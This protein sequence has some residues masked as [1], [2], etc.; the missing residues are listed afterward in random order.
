MKKRIQGNRL[1]G[2]R[3][4]GPS[5]GKMLMMIVD[6]VIKWPEIEQDR[7]MW[8]TLVAE[9]K[10]HF[11]SLASGVSIKYLSKQK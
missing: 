9:A 10:I 8:L 11:R 2:D 5:T 3:S 4:D 7:K 6:A 1:A